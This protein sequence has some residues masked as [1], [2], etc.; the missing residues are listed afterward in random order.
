MD[1]IRHPIIVTAERGN[2]PESHHFVEAVLLAGSADEALV[3][4][5]ADRLIFPRSTLKWIQ[6]LPLVGLFRQGKISAEELALAC[7]SHRGEAEH[8]RVAR[9]WAAR[10]GIGDADLVC[11][12]HP[13]GDEAAAEE[14]IRTAVPR[15]KLFNNCIGKHLGFCHWSL[16][17]GHEPRGYWREDHPAQRLLQANLRELAGT[18]ASLTYGID[19]CGVP[20]YR[21]SL[22]ALATAYLGWLS[23]SEAP[24]ILQ[25]MAAHPKLIGGTASADTWVIPASGGR[26]FMKTGAEGTYVAL[27]PEEG[28]VIALKAGDGNQRASRSTIL[29]FLSQWRAGGADFTREARAKSE[30][31]IQNWAGEKTGQI[32]V[33]GV[34]LT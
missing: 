6:A 17:H 14:L 9:A 32:R 33:D 8:L 28:T 12:F 1:R 5:S 27:I 30:T 2:F 11:G 13:P 22:R 20:N 4:G 10:I 29:A 19:G 7:A 15:S 34:T 23:R 25:A 31:P 18:P 16:E 21:L 24:S 26:V 3:F